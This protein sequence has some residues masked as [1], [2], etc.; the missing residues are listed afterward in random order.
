MQEDKIQFDND[1]SGWKPSEGV[2][3]LPAGKALHAGNFESTDTPDF[4]R[5]D[6]YGKDIDVMDGVMGSSIQNVKKDR[7]N[8]P[9]VAGAL[10]VNPDIKTWDEK[11]TDVASVDFGMSADIKMTDLDFDMVVDSTMSKSMTIDVRPVMMTYEEFYCGFTKDSSEAF[12]VTPVSGKMEKRNGTPTQITVTCDPKGKS[13]E[14]K[15]WL[16]FILPDEKPF[17][18]YY[19]I[20]AKCL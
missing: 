18:T 8:D 5:E 13:G 6:D 2:K 11:L 17:S 20:T 15:G 10:E 9:G 3:D 14:L 16:C 4:F 7:S 1:M 19:S 12:S